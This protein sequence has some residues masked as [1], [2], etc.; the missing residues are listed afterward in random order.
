MDFKLAAQNLLLF[1]YEEN[2]MDDRYRRNDCELGEGSIKLVIIIFFTEDYL[3]AEKGG[4]GQRALDGEQP[5]WMR[6]NLNDNICNNQIFTRFFNTNRLI[7]YKKI[8]FTLNLDNCF[9]IYIVKRTI[10]PNDTQ[11]LDLS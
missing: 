5:T 8:L 6:L 4:H 3:I 10:Q 1:S 9:W 2:Q 7:T 11:T